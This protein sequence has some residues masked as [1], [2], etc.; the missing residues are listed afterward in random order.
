M[1][2]KLTSNKM[3]LSLTNVQKKLPTAVRDAH[4]KFVSVTPK[5]SG[6]ARNKTKLSG[7]TI[8]ANYSYATILNNGYSKQAPQG[9]L[10]PTIA[11]LKQLLKRI[12]RK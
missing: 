4:K 2:I 1:S 8:S 3:T 5:A 10:K 6:N 9:M 11:F 7:N 12:I